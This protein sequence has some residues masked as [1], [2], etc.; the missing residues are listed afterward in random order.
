MFSNS[1]NHINVQCV[2]N[3]PESS[4]S[5]TA[6]YLPSQDSCGEAQDTAGPRTDMRWT[7]CRN[8]RFLPS[9][10][11]RTD[12]SSGS[13]S[14]IFLI[15]LSI[16]F[17]SVGVSLPSFQVTP[18]TPA[19]AIHTQAVSHHPNAKLPQGSL[20]SC[21]L[22]TRGP[23]WT[24]HQPCKPSLVP[25]LFPPPKPNMLFLHPAPNSAASSFLHSVSQ[26]RHLVSS[27]IS[28]PQPSQTGL[29]ILLPKMSRICLLPRS[30]SK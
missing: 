27:L 12:R 5:L 19:V 22:P 14:C 3:C 28:L 25:A 9:R 11:L 26:T 6:P 13:L 20:L 8:H 24:S 2:H 17:L 18:S 1:N 16:S 29:L 30:H 23:T 21:R 15:F 10:L 4:Q 7:G